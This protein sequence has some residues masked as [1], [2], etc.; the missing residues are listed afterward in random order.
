[1][2]DAVGRDPDTESAMSQAKWAGGKSRKID[3]HPLGI[4]LTIRTGP[5]R[6]W[7]DVGPHRRNQF[8][9]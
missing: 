8:G 6:D 1:M 2:V 9:S 4:R 3:R 5:D 7:E